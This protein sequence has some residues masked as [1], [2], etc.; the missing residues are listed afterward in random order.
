M[1]KNKQT[2]V[3]CIKDDEWPAWARA[4]LEQF[5][6]KDVVYTIRDV[7][8]AVI[9]QEVVKD[10]TQNNPIQFTGPVR[11]ALLLEELVNPKHPVFGNEYA[12]DA[13]RFAPLVPPE[14]EKVKEKVSKPKKVVKPKKLESPKVEE[15][16]TM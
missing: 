11:P 9:G 14:E 10:P 1:S 2:K 15:S 7:I 5:P 3:V 8:P 4:I 12:F 13:I 16:I 6:V